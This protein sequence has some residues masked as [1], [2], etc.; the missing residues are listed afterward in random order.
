MIDRRLQRKLDQAILKQA[1]RDFWL[2]TDGFR[3]TGDEQEECIDLMLDAARWFFA[4]PPSGDVFSFRQI[5]ERSGIAPVKAAVAIFAGLPD[6]RRRE[7]WRALRHYRNRLLPLSWQACGPAKVPEKHPR[8]PRY[9]RFGKPRKN[10]D[11]TARS[12]KKQ[13]VKTAA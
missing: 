1:L 7:I 5:S 4:V 6:E 13:A 11:A 12:S 2:R 8:R 3:M 9:V 10:R